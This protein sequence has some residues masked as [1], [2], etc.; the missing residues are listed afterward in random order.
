MLQEHKTAAALAAVFLAASTAAGFA[1]SA[2]KEGVTKTELGSTPSDDMMK[3]WNIDIA[4]DGRNLPDGSGSVSQGQEIFA[5]TC[6]ACHG[7]KGEGGE[8]MIGGRLVGGK[9]TLATGKPVKT[10]GSYWPYATTL[11]DYV[12]RAMPFNAPQSLTPD[13]VYAVSAYVLNLNGIVPDDAVMDKETLAKVEMPNR[14]GFVQMDTKTLAKTT[15][16]M[17]DCTPLDVSK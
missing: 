13:Q 3:A 5:S 14:D 10:V 6:A 16:C 1:Q 8:G 4:P 7:E 12:H 2:G 17:K 9:D 11:Y 15:A